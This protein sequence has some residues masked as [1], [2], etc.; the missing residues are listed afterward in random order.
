M[1]IGTSGLLPILAAAP[2]C[3]DIVCDVNKL[4]VEEID[5][6]GRLIRK[7]PNLTSVQLY[8][9]SGMGSISR[10]WCKHF[11][12]ALRLIQ[13]SL[14]CQHEDLDPAHFDQASVSFR[15]L[16]SLIQQLA[17]PHFQLLVDSRSATW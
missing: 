16:A 8:G 11:K 12:P 15:G 1:Y 4:M 9:I 5:L 14:A 3:T 13:L 10:N 6:L 7:N 2:P 17:Y